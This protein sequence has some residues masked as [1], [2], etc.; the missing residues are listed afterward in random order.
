MLDS[1]GFTLVELLA[2][3]VI[4]AILMAIAIPS[5]ANLI[6]ISNAKKCEAYEK[7]ISEYAKAYYSESNLTGTISLSLLKENLQ[8]NEL[9]SL[10]AACNGYIDLSDNY[11]AYITCSD[12]CESEGFNSDYLYEGA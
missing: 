3:I 12:Y 11:K 5:I 10:D 8:N 6:D 7:T 4:M 1:K 9:A 2:V